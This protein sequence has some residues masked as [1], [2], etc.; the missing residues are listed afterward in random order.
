M[1]L[2]TCNEHESNSNTETL[3]GEMTNPATDVEMSPC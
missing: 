1:D 3:S 2:N